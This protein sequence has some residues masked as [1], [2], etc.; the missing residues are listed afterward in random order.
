MDASAAGTATRTCYRHPN[1]VTGVSCSNCGRPICPDCMTP[2]SVGMRCPECARQRTKVHN[3]RTMSG[4]PRVTVGLIIVNAVLFLG[5]GSFG[6]GSSGGN[7]LFDNF[8][9]FGPAIANNHEY[10]RLITGGFLHAG[11]LHILFNMYL[12]WILGQMLEPTLGPTRFGTLYF[13]AL[14]WG[15]FGAL[16]LKPDALTVG[17]SGAVFGLMG[18]A[19]VELRSR[20]I[21][22]F[23]TSIGTLILLNLGL[24][25]LFA[26]SISIGGH[27]GGLIGG[28]LAG[29]AL[30]YADRHRQRAVGYA[31]CAVLCVVAIVGAIAAAG[32]NGLT[33]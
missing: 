30:G 19:A 2:T 23:Q 12:L 1:R 29:L 21:N 9:L 18:A 7:R 24:S 15:S 8:A 14:L 22:P 31:A 33:G 13:T 16:L 26:G 11:F 3:M 28:A 10:W 6:I 25:F 20:G 17:A 27:I 5:S 4:D 32:G